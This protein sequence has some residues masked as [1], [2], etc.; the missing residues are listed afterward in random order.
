MLS[1]LYKNIFLYMTYI[2][3]Y[4]NKRN[5]KVLDEP[6]PILITNNLD[7]KGHNYEKKLQ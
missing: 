3:K 6:V 7:K 2:R 1:V 4:L 5:V